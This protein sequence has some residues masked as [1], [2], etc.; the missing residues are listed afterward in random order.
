MLSSSQR[1]EKTRSW[2]I[3]LCTII[4][5]FSMSTYCLTYQYSD[6]VVRFDVIS[7]SS[8]PILNRR[9]G[10]YTRSG[11]HLRFGYATISSLEVSEGPD[12][13]WLRDFYLICEKFLVGDAVVI[14]RTW[15]I[16]QGAW[17]CYASVLLWFASF[18]ICL[19]LTNQKFR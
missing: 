15:A 19:V 17:P 11:A 1:E 8:E 9:Y 7:F 5:M 12:H 6:L 2:V 3:L 10:E 16:W 18:G 14:W 4:L 13:R